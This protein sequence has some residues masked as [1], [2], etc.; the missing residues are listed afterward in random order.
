MI[1]SVFAILSVRSCKHLE[2]IS[3]WGILYLAMHL[4]RKIYV[5]EANLKV[6]YIW[7]V[8]EA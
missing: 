2:F 6:V 3:G 7:M 4:W 8:P 5:A 1:N